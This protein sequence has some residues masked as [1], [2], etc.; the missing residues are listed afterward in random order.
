MNPGFTFTE[1]LTMNTLKFLASVSFF[2]FLGT[3]CS[4]QSSPKGVYRF[5]DKSVEIIFAENE[6][7]PYVVFLHN[8]DM[9][10]LK[11]SAVPGILEYGNAIGLFDTIQG[12]FRFSEN[13]REVYWRNG[14]EELTGRRLNLTEKELN[15]KNDKQDLSGTLVLPEGS[16][17]FPCI[18]ML[19]GSGPE[20]REG[21]RG[22]G[23][24]FASNGIAVF[25]Y[26]KRGTGKSRADDWRDSFENYA[27][28]GLAALDK[29]SQE[30][31]IDKGRIGIYGHSQGGWIA[32]LA[33]SKTDK[34]SFVILSAANAV[35]PVEQHLYNGSCAYRQ[36]GLR[37]QAIQ[38]IYEFRLTKYEAGITG[39][40][41]NFEAALP[42]AKEKPWFP[43]TGD[44][45]PT[46]IFWRS[47]GYY[48]AEPAIRA[49]K[50][51]VLLMA[52]ELDKYT[53][54]KKNMNLFR[55]IFTNSGNNNI[56]YKIF[57]AANH[58]LMETTTGKLDDSEML[59]LKRFVP[60]FK[61]TLLEWLKVVLKM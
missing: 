44:G 29:V 16:G 19:Q 35:T 61:E 1:I 27:A 41:K 23:Y 3:L 46:D 47:N 6:G 10:G 11:P 58:A 2:L 60:G 7:H 9:R 42:V 36:A 38:E 54:T 14:G 40:R 52:G 15:F 32:P 25:I 21:S 8:G 50:C 22:L 28:D 34:F 45:L 33:A 24:L 31:K 48:N 53:D 17:P 4:S 51:P 43:R 39:N 37:E 26:D 56:T 18:I 55:D 59:Q 30:K 5:A 20:T 13:M 12:Q 57:P 49:L